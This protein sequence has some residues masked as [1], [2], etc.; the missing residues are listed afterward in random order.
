TSSGR[1]ARARP[2]SVTSTTMDHAVDL[3]SEVPEEIAGGFLSKLPYVWEPIE[4]FEFA[5][6]GRNRVRFALRPGY[7][8]SASEVAERIA[9]I[10]HAM[11]RG[12]RPSPEKILVS[13]PRP[14]P[15]TDDPHPL[16]EARGDLWRHGS[17][18]YSLG[19]G[20]VR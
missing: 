8:A 5:A 17:G 20:L 9:T 14:V 18:R 10:A 13:R 7:D 4:H 19:P 3:K 2:R 11:T 1:S 6:R 16:L 12:Y 15:F